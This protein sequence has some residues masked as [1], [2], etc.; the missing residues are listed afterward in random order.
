MKLGSE[1]KKGNKGMVI[2]ITTIITLVIMVLLGSPLINSIKSLF[3]ETSYLEL[4]EDFNAVS[5]EQA[6]NS[7]VIFYS[8]FDSELK[9]DKR[10]ELY[11]VTGDISLSTE[12]YKNGSGSAYFS[13][14]RGQS[15][16]IDRDN[17]N[18]DT[19]DF[20]IEFYAYAESQSMN[21]ATIFSDESGRSLQY[22]IRDNSCSYNMS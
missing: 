4:Q 10:N 13:G 18:L 2:K 5:Y 1:F 15:L 22:M 11:T 14:E 12:N 6:W 8:S 19:S 9:E 20:T 17:L 21:N 3:T 7:H 16:R